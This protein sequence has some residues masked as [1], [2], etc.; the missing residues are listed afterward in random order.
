MGAGGGNGSAGSRDGGAAGGAAAAGGQQDRAGG[1][2]EDQGWEHVAGGQH[3]RGQEQCACT[4]LVL[5]GARTRIKEA[6]LLVPLPPSLIS[7]LS[8]S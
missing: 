4:V 5:Q 6:A 1:V 8:T 3:G 7:W 2:D